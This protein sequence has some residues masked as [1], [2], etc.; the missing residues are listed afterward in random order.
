MQNFVG[1]TNYATLFLDQQEICHVAPGILAAVGKSDHT[2]HL[3]VMAAAAIICQW[4]V[5]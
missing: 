3:R 5:E 2:K 4:N 1:V